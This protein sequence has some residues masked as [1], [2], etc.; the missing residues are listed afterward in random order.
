[1]ADGAGHFAGKALTPFDVQIPQ[2]T[3][4]RIYTKVLNYPWFE[5]PSGEAGFA[6]GMDTAAL[7]ALCTYWIEGFDWRAQEAK[8]N[9]WPHYMA[10]VDGLPIHFVHV[11]GE[12]DGKRPLLITHGW[13]GSFFEFWDTIE[14]LAFPSRHGGTSADA[15]DLVIPS[16]PGFAF[17][18]KPSRPIG[19][20]AT[21]KLWNSLMTQVL[22]YSRFMA[23]GGDWG[24][25][26]SSRLALEYP[27]CAALHL[28]FMGLQPADAN[29]RDEQERQWLDR[30]QTLLRFEGAYLMQQMTKPQSLAF[31]LM[32]S[33]VGAA[34]WILEKFH[35]WSDLQEGDLLSVYS[36]DQL[37][38]NLM[39]YLTTD[40]LAT[41]L[42]FYRGFLEEGANQLV[43][44]QRVT[45]RTGFANFPGEKVYPAPPLSW[46]E[47]CYDIAR[48]TAMPKG[49]HFAAMEQPGLF[50]EEL[51][52]FARQVSY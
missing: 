49:G 17:S 46:A 2:S 33:P 19:P 16:L 27:A 28:N 32:D 26:V 20:R 40:S 50:V 15:F 45:S 1:M 10:E 7:R 48:W 43:H 11:R 36:K 29:P 42:W 35:G 18:G 39:L 41:S 47:R 21:A 37:L 12:A 23:Q 38:T 8:L 34:A 31:A 25:V 13:P 14:P 22:G 6:Y 24:A 52:A 30:T 3:L 51:R 9:I 44:G 4:D 5:A